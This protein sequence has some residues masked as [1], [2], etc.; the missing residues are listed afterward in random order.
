MAKAN[1]LQ[2]LVQQI[3]DLIADLAKANDPE[4]EELPDPIEQIGSLKVQS[5]EQGER[6]QA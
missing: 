1:Q 5:A 6:P 2:D 3:E 4:I